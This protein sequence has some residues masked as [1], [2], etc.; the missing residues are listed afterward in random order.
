MLAQQIYSACKLGVGPLAESFLVSGICGDIY[1]QRLHLGKD[2]ALLTTLATRGVVSMLDGADTRYAAFAFAEYG[3][4]IQS[5][6]LMTG[7]PNPARG[8]QHAFAL[9]NP[10]PTPYSSGASV[11]FLNSFSLGGPASYWT[12]VGVSNVLSLA[13][14]YTGTVASVTGFSDSSFSA[15]GAV[16]NVTTQW[17]YFSQPLSNVQ[18]TVA[19]YYGHDCGV[20][21]RVTGKKVCHR[22]PGMS[23]ATL[24]AAY[25]I[26]SNTA[27]CGS[28]LVAGTAFDTCLYRDRAGAWSGP[29]GT[30][31]YTES[32][33]LC[34]GSGCTVLSSSLVGLYDGS[35]R[36]FATVSCT[37]AT[38]TKSGKNLDIVVAGVTSITGTANQITASASTGAVTLSTPNPF[39]A[40]Q[41]APTVNSYGT[42]IGTAGN[43]GT[44]LGSNNAFWVT[45]TTGSAPSAGGLIARLDWATAWT[46]VTAVNGPAC[47]V[48][49]TNP[50]GL[51]DPADFMSTYGPK[52]YA[53]PTS[54]SVLTSVDLK[55]A[56][57]ASAVALPA[58]TSFEVLVTC[59]LVK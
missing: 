9:V 29:A 54:G 56:T 38:C 49:I 28:G 42:A 10:S 48:T 37:G 5:T 58:V 26:D 15:T 35:D 30:D 41:A 25:L 16:L 33:F 7:V 36:A 11:T 3:S 39:E 17:G 40:N 50:E 46:T 32:G 19:N 47:R 4:T 43:L 2:I 8:F 24:N 52:I 53:I 51:S 34:A 31:I 13:A 55:I 22:S 21:T 57:G 44:I 20:T 1:S 59:N 27:S 12:I 6:L 18:S 23:G 45:I 14:N